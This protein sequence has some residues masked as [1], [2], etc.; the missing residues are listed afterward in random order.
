MTQRIDFHR[1]REEV[2]DSLDQRLVEFLAEAGLIAVPVS[3]GLAAT[4][5][6]HSHSQSAIDHFLERIRPT[7]VVLSGGNDLDDYPMRNVVEHCLLRYA[8]QN[9]VPVLG[10]C[11]GMQAMAVFAGTSLKPAK[12]HVRTRHQLSGIVQNNVNSFHRFSLATCPDDYQVLA[13]SEDGEIEAIRHQQLPWEGWMWHPERD[14]PFSR[15]DITR[16][17]GLY[18]RD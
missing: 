10:I 14:V 6:G 4:V 5:H 8:N 3:N 2:R 16:L 17:R 18:A 13:Q 9:R 11:R 12:G 1:E 15:N 7:V